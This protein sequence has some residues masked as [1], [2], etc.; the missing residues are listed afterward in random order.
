MTITSGARPDVEARAQAEPRRPGSFA[1]SD[2]ASLAA[3]ALSAGA[4]VWLA[5]R[6]L[7]LDGPLGFVVCWYILFLAIYRLVVR[8]TQGPLAAADRVA[9]VLVVSGAVVAVVPLV[10][11]VYLVL[12]RGLPTL[13]GGFPHFFTRTQA[14]FGPL[15][16]ATAGGAKHSIVGTLEQVG[17]A[18]LISVPIAVLTAVYLNEIGGRMAP[19]LR[20]IVD[21]MSGVPSI[22]AGLFVFAFWILRYR[23]GFSGVAGSM[24]VTIL[25][26]PTVTRTAEEVLRIVPG[27]LREAALALGAPEWRMVLKV[28]LPTARSGLVTASILGVAR[29]VGE[30]APMILTAF[31][32]RVWNANPFSGA[33]DDLPLFVYG[34]IH[35]SRQSQLDQAW[36]GALVLVLLVLALFVLARIAGSRRP[37]AGRL[38]SRVRRLGIRARFTGRT[39]GAGDRFTPGP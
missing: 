32:A 27:G 21:A 7:V 37:G 34:L 31:G 22:V 26:L 16:P 19:S 23:N 8:Q 6:L 10:F 38:R 33:Q 4:F 28:V 15:D 25:M 17:V 18:T 36:T 12:V 9:G 13:L 29:A 11:I 24:A 3:S 2:L 14:T 1:L 20:F 30:T 35:S 39:P 5:F